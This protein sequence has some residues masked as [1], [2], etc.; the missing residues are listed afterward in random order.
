MGHE[1]TMSEMSEADAYDE[2]PVITPPAQVEPPVEVTAAD[3]PDADQV[4]AFT[5]AHRSRVVEAITKSGI[6]VNDK[7]QMTALLKTL[8]GMDKQSLGRKRMDADKE[9]AQGTNDTNTALLASILKSIPNIARPENGGEIPIVR[10]VPVLPADIVFDNPVDGQT[11]KAPPQ[12]TYQSFMA[13]QIS[14][15]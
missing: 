12:D 15:S 8:D 13:R 10:E 14:R 4:L 5:H 7:E 11:E 9:I 2:A 3:V 6:P 1:N